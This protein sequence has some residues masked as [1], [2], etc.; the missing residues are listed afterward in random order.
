MIFC[1]LVTMTLANDINSLNQTEHEYDLPCV[2]QTIEIESDQINNDQIN[3]TNQEKTY[4]A[5]L[6]TT[7]CSCV[8]GLNHGLYV[9]VLCVY[10]VFVNRMVV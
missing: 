7:L 5:T 10:A 3:Q 1:L 4:F 6:L 8:F 9:V 2:N